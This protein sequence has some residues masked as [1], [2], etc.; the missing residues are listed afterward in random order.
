MKNQCNGLN[1]KVFQASAGSGK[2]YTIV[3]EYLKLCLGSAQS[4]DNFRSILAITFTNASAN[5]MK[6]KILD[7][8]NDIIDSVVVNPKTMEADLIAELNI[9][10]AELKQNAKALRTRII[11]DYSSFCVSTIDSFV[12]KLARTFAR[13]LNLP[14][15]YTVSIDKDDIAATIV[16]NLAMRISDDNS[17]LVESLK[18]FSKEQFA[19]EGAVM[20]QSVLSDFVSS[21]MKEKAF[22]KD[23]KNNIK[24]LP[25]YNQT[26][27]FLKL[28]LRDF[29]KLLK[30]FLDD[31]A[32]IE[33]KYDLSVVDYS[34]GTRGFVSFINKLTKGKIEL[35]SSS[36]A[37]V[38]ADGTK[39]V[40]TKGKRRFDNAEIQLIGDEMSQLFSKF[41]M[42]YE[43]DL[44]SY[45]FYKSQHDLLY[46]YA[47]RVQIREEFDRLRD[48]D[49]VVPISEF[50]KLL[51]QVMGDFSVPFV[52]ER[53]GEHFHHVFVDEFQDTSVLQWQNLLPLIDNGLASNEMSMVVGDGK[54]S[55]YRFRSGEVEQI[56]QLPEIHALPADER[57]DAFVQ[58]QK[59]LIANFGFTNLG[60]NYRSFANVVE[61]NNAF[62]KSTVARES[63]VVQKVYEDENET[64]KKKVTIKQK[65]EIED[66]GL[67]QVEL[68]DAEEQPDYYCE[69]IKELV[70]ELQGKGYG[71]ADITVLVRSSKIGSKV[72]NY[73]NDKD[74]PVVSADSILLKTSNKVQLLI[75]TLDYLVNDNNALVVANILYFSQLVN[76]PCFRGDVGSL[77]DAAV[78]VANRTTTLE[79]VLHLP[80]NAFV[81]ALSKSTC[82]Y[83]LCASLSRIYGIEALQDAYLNYFMEEVSAFQSSQREGIK[84]FLDFWALKQDKLAVKMEPSDAVQI[85]T[86]HKSKGLEFNVVIYPDAI[87]DLNE[88]LNNTPTEE[89]VRPSDI[90][91]DPIPHL[92][93]VIL[94]LN[95]DS[96]LMGKKAAGRY[97]KEVED[98]RLDNLNLLYVAFTRAKQRLYVIAKQA[99]ADKP[100]VIRDFLTDKEANRVNDA[101]V[102]NGALMYRFGNAGFVNPK[103][104]QPQPVQKPSVPS[105]TVDWMSRI[106]VDAMASACW[107][108]KDDRMSPLEWGETVHGILAKIHTVD[109]IDAALL[110]YLLD[111]TLDMEMADLLKDKFLQMTVHPL[112]APAFVPAAIVKNECDILFDG[113]VKRPDRYAELSDVIYLLD[114]K[115]GKPSDDY[116]RQLRTYACA[117]HEMVDKEIRAF[118]VYLSG[119]EVDV[120]TVA[121][122]FSAE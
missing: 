11:H 3:K 67:V 81:D 100:N 13:D 112:I 32:A 68:Y 46:L 53:I 113:K 91:F 12:Q 77:F 57:H 79:N 63:A 107:S 116:Q 90:D 54:Q 7:Q 65:V 118:L 29:E 75:N 115:T 121:V 85:K 80:A 39:W 106:K 9:S 35:P 73:L 43:S 25:Q 55:I 61:F 94:K 62:F 41:L 122:D 70:A 8:L 21:L 48:D 31:F 108:A 120:Q 49:E 92:D 102:R 51:N 87:I 111:G 59:N 69:R 5:D 33:R 23:E 66:D 22:Q 103:Q 45:L 88:K 2:T 37:D 101:T 64:Y 44:A 6:K 71:L 93:K 17:L 20:P 19:K 28:K 105:L 56:V 47:L 72:A 119:N 58:Y 52:Y 15:Q 82:L 78:P 34:N 4:V 60:S 109:D 14:S 98:V 104:A 74:I 97:E 24:D 96:Q 27:E 50:N 76:N 99:P 16:E 30:A 83:D 26:L 1:F 114:Y 117:L 38:A 18:Q 10:D 42:N 36:F 84:E 89:W 110:P 40:S 86:I 95:K